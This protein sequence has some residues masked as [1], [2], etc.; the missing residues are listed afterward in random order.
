MTPFKSSDTPL[1]SSVSDWLAGN[2]LASF[3]HAIVELSAGCQ[4][5][6]LRRVF[7]HEL[8][9]F[10]QVRSSPP[11]FQPHELFLVTVQLRLLYEHD[12]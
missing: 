3:T 7:A 12:A 11:F 8:G 10:F 2:Y 1:C 4:E 5:V 6:E 9:V